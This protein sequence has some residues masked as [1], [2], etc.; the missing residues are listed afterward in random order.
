M[1][2]LRI[3][4]K[5][6]NSLAGE[7]EIDL[8]DPVYVQNGIFAITGP[9]GAGKSTLLDAICLALYGRTP[10]LD[11]ISRTSNEIMS[12]HTGECWAEV[13][14]ETSAG[15]YLCRWSQRRARL[16]SGGELQQP[17]QE[18]SNAVTGEILSGKI[19]ETA[20][21]IEEITG[22]DFDRFTRSMLLAQG[23]FAAFLQ[24]GADARAPILEQIT[25]TGIY[26]TISRR[27]HERLGIERAGLAALETEKAS[28]RMLSPEE[29]E[30]LAARQAS[31]LLESKELRD[32]IAKLREAA[33]WREHLDRLLDQKAEVEVAQ[34]ALEREWTDFSPE[35]MRLD[36]AACA[37]RVEPSHFFLVSLRQEQQVETS[38]LDWLSQE[39]PQ[40]EQEAVSARNSLTRAENA[41]SALRS[42]QQESI[43]VLREI[44]ELDRQLAD[45]YAREQAAAEEEKVKEKAAGDLGAQSEALEHTSRLLEDERKRLEDEILRNGEDEQLSGRMPGIRQRCALY[46]TARRALADSTDRLDKAR[47]RQ[48]TAAQKLSALVC[49]EKEREGG[50][51]S[52]RERIGVLTS[53]RSELLC[54]RTV[55]QCREES[56]VLSGHQY[57]LDQA[58]RLAGLLRVAGERIARGEA[59][60]LKLAHEKK[61]AQRDAR[62]AEL[63]IGELDARIGMLQSRRELNRVRLLYSQARS[64]LAEG[65]P[66][67]VCGSTSHPFHDKEAVPETDVFETGD[68]TD[69]ET[70]AEEELREAQKA[71][72]AARIRLAALEKSLEGLDGQL[73]E[74]KG[75]ADTLEAELASDRAVLSGMSDAEP[76]AEAPFK[77]W[78]AE[79]EST[80]AVLMEK[81]KALL[82]AV[83]RLDELLEKERAALG[84][85]EAQASDREKEGQI[86]RAEASKTVAETDR[87]QAERDGHKEILDTRLKEIR[88]ELSPYGMESPAA[89][90]IPDFLRALDERAVRA[91]T[92][93]ARM[94]EILIENNKLAEQRAIVLERTRHTEASLEEVRLARAALK[95]EREMVQA[96]RI[97]R[98]GTRDPDREE[99]AISDSLH[100]SEQIAMESRKTCERAEKDFHE[101][102]VRIDALQTSLSARADRIRNAEADFAGA[103]LSE[104]F[105]DEETFLAACLSGSERAVLQT[106][107]D[108]LEQR[109]TGLKARGAEIALQIEREETRAPTDQSAEVLRDDVLRREQRLSALDSE[110]GALRQ[111]LSA[112]QETTRRHGLLLERIAVREGICRDWERLHGLIGSADGKKFRNFAQGVTFDLLIGHANHQ[113]S[114]LSDRYLLVHDPDAPLELAVIDNDQAGDIRSTKNL[115][116]GESFL[117]SLSLALGLSRMSS[118]KVRVD[119]LF[120]D[121]GF[122]TLDDDTLE[123]AL[124]TLAGL[125]QEGKLIGLISHVPAIRERI[126]AKI[127]VVPVAGGRSRLVG[128]G[129]VDCSSRPDSI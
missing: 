128:P 79:R 22:M 87:L 52:A 38:R 16:R 82:D 98:Y 43:P 34:Q 68:A 73:A 77:Q 115:S 21:I 55:S 104:G 60:R 40:R 76:D 101:H 19:R 107:S 23:G 51:S 53:Q 106:K 88:E 62:E 117:V 80:L 9:T 33:A 42:R 14:F 124:E 69:E 121:E 27:V 97:S 29:E 129:C 123:S 59:D 72:V 54:G 32:H 122:G 125:R 74:K 99:K 102:V 39:R 63:R 67:P 118:R 71:Q 127:Q 1:R 120:L 90:T 78:I 93:G 10:R 113:L 45:R 100:V 94:S 2:I 96:D 24:A 64:A 46:E 61:Q 58:K 95:K 65:V 44:R 84:K 6:L 48:N 105:A 103:L 35:R 109:R 18:I 85:L 89:D 81:N 92:R 57:R 20:G 119:S 41:L 66:C 26:S 114:R 37:A 47:D 126:P 5:N 86:I 70:K 8:T 13:S 28:L 12:R 83:D 11:R 91:R 7:W 17:A 56:R 111:Q 116:G 112:Q 30:T 25:G 15:R 75:E 3:R 110:A 108:E 36:L 4:F 49:E 50:L 31:I